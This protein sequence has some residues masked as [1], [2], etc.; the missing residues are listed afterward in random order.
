[1]AHQLVKQLIDEPYCMEKE[2]VSAVC[3]R[4]RVSMQDIQDSRRRAGK[5][6]PQDIFLLPYAPPADP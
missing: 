2:T 5:E 1:M 3:D 6:S 4:E